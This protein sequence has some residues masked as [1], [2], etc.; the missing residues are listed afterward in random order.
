MSPLTYYWWSGQQRFIIG[1]QLNFSS[2]ATLGTEKSGH[3][4]EMD[5]VER[6]NP[7]M[8]LPA[9]T[10][11]TRLHCFKTLPELSLRERKLLVPF[12]GIA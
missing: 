10:G 7:L 1:I 8:A 5:V 12:Q 9:K 4:K 11:R 2:M 6:F 3:C